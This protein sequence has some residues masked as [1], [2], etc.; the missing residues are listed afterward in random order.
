MTLS[1]SI[2]VP[3]ATSVAA[4]KFD[5]TTPAGEN[6][7]SGYS[8]I[9]VFGTL[10]KAVTAPTVHSTLGADGKLTL[11]GVGGVPGGNYTWLTSTNVAAPLS[12]W[13]TNSTGAF[14]AAGSFSVTVPITP[15][16]TARFFRL[17][18]P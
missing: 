18:T 15:A 12:T 4:L 7:F 5:F 10:S 16:E 14:D 9:A 3:L 11:N 13:T 2:S 8:E 17:V 6:G 1:S